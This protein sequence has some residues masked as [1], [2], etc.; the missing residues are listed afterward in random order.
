MRIIKTHFNKSLEQKVRNKDLISNVMERLF[1][2]CKENA[3]QELKGK[4]DSTSGR[5]EELSKKK[6]KL[7]QLLESATE[8]KKDLA[9]KVEDLENLNFSKRS[10]LLEEL[11]SEL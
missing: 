10:Q 6:R 2:I 4:I 8:A 7:Q 9:E 5:I 3:N 1:V 11:G